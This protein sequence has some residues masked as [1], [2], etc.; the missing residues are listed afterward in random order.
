[1]NTPVLSFCIASYNKAD[2]TE[3]LVKLILTVKNDEF[4][5]VVVDNCSSDDTIER[6]KAI[7]SDRLTI[8]KNETNIGGAANTIKAPYCGNGLFSLYVNDRDLIYPEKIPAFIEFLKN[9]PGIQA[10]TVNR[11]KDNSYGQFK[12]IE[13]KDALLKY[14]YRTSHPTGFFYNKRALSKV[15]MS[16]ITDGILS[17]IDFVPLVHEYLFARLCCHGQ[18]AVYNE[19]IWRST[20]NETHNKYVSGYVNLE[21]VNIH[22][23]WFHPDDCLRRSKYSIQDALKLANDYNIKYSNEDLQLFLK[24]MLHY[25]TGIG[26]WR[27]RTIMTTPS[28]AYHYA[29]PTRHFGI[30]EA[31]ST[32]YKLRRDYKTMLCDL[33][34]IDKV[35]WQKVAM[36]GIIVDLV[37]CRNYLWSILSKIKH[38]IVG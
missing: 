21:N 18:I 17:V 6:L 5:I 1:M 27:Y 24:S 32:S 7:N 20:G 19:V 23:K 2:L 14:S 26:V 33:K 13:S 38:K 37:Q 30:F 34:L 29:V 28:L 31:L 35:N 22:K 36:G 8:V 16:E 25:E 15:S 11:H 10:G 3:A 12:L 4:D 9:N